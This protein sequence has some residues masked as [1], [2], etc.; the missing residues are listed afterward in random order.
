[1]AQTKRRRSSKIMEELKKK[2]DE[3]PI[4]E[5][6]EDDPKPNIT[7]IDHIK[8]LQEILVQTCIDYINKNNLT[9]IYKVIF[10]ADSLEES[11][12]FGEWQPCTDSYIRVEGICH[13]N[14]KRKNGEI[15]KMP[16]RYDIGEYM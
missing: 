6:L 13:E 9:D 14:Y 16:Y 2:W 5:R 8:E 4:V 7:T 3:N 12:R 11:S 15:I 1:M 10:N